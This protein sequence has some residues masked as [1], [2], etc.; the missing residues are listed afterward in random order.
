[1][2]GN[3]AALKQGGLPGTWEVLFK[4]A[5][6]AINEIARHGRADPFWTFGGGGSY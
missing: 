4:A 1:M 2:Q 6:T 5:L 3:L